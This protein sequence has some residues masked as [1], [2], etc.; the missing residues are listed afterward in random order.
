M[1]LIDG[2]ARPEISAMDRGLAYGD[3]IF[4]TL[5]TREGRPL[6]WRRHYAK[7][8]HDAARL[9]LAVPEADVLEDEVKTVCKDHGARAVKIILTRGAGRRGYVYAGDE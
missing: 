6:L 1:I 3:G 5:A 4:R 8:V 9:K 7:L 2:E